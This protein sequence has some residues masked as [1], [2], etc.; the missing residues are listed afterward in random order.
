M[1]VVSGARAA[2][3]TPATDRWR[4]LAPLP[5]ARAGARA[6]WDGHE[7]LVVGGKNAPVEGFAYDPETNRWRR[8]APM[9]SGRAGAAAVWTGKRLSCGAGRPGGLARS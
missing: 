3:Y 7:L 5:E 6:V 8:L 2:A 4:L 9:D 1:I